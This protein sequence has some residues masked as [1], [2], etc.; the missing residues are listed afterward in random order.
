MIGDFLYN[1]HRLFDFYK[2]GEITQDNFL[3]LFSHIWLLSW[4]YCMKVGSLDMWLDVNELTKEE[5]MEQFK[6]LNLG[7]RLNSK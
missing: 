2:K 3:M 6:A 1:K 4:P 5:Q 7:F